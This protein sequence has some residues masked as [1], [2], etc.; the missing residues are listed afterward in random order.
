MPFHSSRI[1]ADVVSTAFLAL[2]A[3]TNSTG[4]DEFDILVLLASYN[5]TQS[6]H[7]SRCRRILIRD[8]MR[9]RR[10]LPGSTALIELL[11]A[12]GTSTIEVFEQILPFVPPMEEARARRMLRGQP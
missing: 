9:R 12:A 3:K 2:S 4:S 5:G 1:R 10:N 7:G 8:N 6:V 11:E